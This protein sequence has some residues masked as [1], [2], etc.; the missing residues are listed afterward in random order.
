MERIY[1][2]RR[3]LPTV[4]PMP[5]QIYVDGVRAR[6][7]HGSLPVELTMTPTGYAASSDVLAS[8]RNP[9]AFEMVYTGGNAVWGWSFHLRLPEVGITPE[10]S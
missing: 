5:R 1:G 3:R 8:W 6:R 4:V 7:T 9:Q 2:G 10:S